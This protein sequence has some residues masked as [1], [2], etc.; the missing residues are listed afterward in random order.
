ADELVAVG[1]PAVLLFGVPAP[2]R[3]DPEGR[4]SYA[5]EGA[6]QRAIRTLKAHAPDLVVITD[7]CMCE[8]TS[9]GHCGILDSRQYLVNDE[10]LESLQR[11]AVSHAEAGADIVAP[12]GMIDGAVGAIRTAL[13]EAGYINVAI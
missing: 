10:T 6:V 5:Q 8:Y 11:I 2:D 4:E 7:V 1:V 13:D 12:S 3:K 9:H